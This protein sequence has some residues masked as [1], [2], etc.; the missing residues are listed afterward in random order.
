MFVPLPDPYEVFLGK[1][2]GRW[3]MLGFQTGSDVEDEP[4]VIIAN[5]ENG[6][7]KRVELEE[8]RICPEEFEFEDEE[9]DDEDGKDPADRWKDGE[10]PV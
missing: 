8:I 10:P 2:Q 7:L 1:S 5:M 4:K 9:E 3:L 6:K